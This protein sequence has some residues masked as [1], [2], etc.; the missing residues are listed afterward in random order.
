MRYTVTISGEEVAERLRKAPLVSMENLSKQM[1]IEME[2]LRSYIAN[3]KLRGQVLNSK[4]GTIIDSVQATPTVTNGAIVTGGVEA[5]G[6]PAFYAIYFEKG[7]VK[8]YPILPKVKKALAFLTPEQTI[9]PR[10]QEV[11]NAMRSG[12]AAS[13]SARSQAIAKFRQYNGTVVGSVMHPKTKLAPFMEPSYEE[14]KE[15]IAARLKMSVLKGLV[16]PNAS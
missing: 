1:T 11:V 7:G 4:Q 2:S 8:D 14:N 12:F 10:N 16:D 3:N 5:G 6:G 9:V 13:G 15:G